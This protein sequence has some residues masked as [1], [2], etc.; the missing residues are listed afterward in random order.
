MIV[1]HIGGFMTTVGCEGLRVLLVDVSERRRCR[2]H[3]V[4]EV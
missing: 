4:P 3:K 1:G 2:L